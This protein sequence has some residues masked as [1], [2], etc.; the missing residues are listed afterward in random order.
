VE[1]HEQLPPAGRPGGHEQ[2]LAEVAVE[3][4]AVERE[5]LDADGIR[6]C[7]ARVGSSPQFGDARSAASP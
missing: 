5:R 4:L 2:D 1:E 7:A 3:Q 6:P